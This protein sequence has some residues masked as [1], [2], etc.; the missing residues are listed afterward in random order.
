MRKE[1]KHMETPE[2][3]PIEQGAT[4]LLTM[5]EG[6][7][8]YGIPLSSMYELAAKGTP[9]FVRTGRAVK[10]HRLVF[11]GWLLRQAGGDWIAAQT[12]AIEPRDAE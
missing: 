7:A 6:G 3:P 4:L 11:E 5:K 2:R 8:K 9:G 1:H 12:R 10:V